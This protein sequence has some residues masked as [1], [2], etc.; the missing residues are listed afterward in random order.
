[1]LSDR[2][3]SL[4][5]SRGHAWGGFGTPQEGKGSCR[6]D[7]LQQMPISYGGPS[8]CSPYLGL[9]MARLITK[10]DPVVRHN[11]HGGGPACAL[12]IGGYSGPPAT[13]LAPQE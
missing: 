10:R 7:L 13:F 6:A 2:F 8:R 3:D 1:M 9:G 11:H 12:L 4:A 5:N